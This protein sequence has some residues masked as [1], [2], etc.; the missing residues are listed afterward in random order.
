MRRQCLALH[1][2]QLYLVISSPCCCD[3]HRRILLLSAG[4]LGNNFVVSCAVGRRRSGG[5]RRR[6]QRGS[7]LNK[8]GTWS[9]AAPR[10]PHT[11]WRTATAQCG[12]VQRNRTLRVTAAAAASDAVDVAVTSMRHSYGG[13]VP[14]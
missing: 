7:N 8:Q 10:R 3:R 11:K 4:S 1:F 13:N 12:D 14:V 9:G 2:A 5:Q 6:A